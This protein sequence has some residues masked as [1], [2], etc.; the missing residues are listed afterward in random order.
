MPQDLKPDKLKMKRGDDPVFQRSGDLVA[1]A[2]Q[3]VKRVTCLSTVHTNNTCDK[4][5]RERGNP[6]GRQLEKPVMIEEY[7]AKMSGVD[8]MD[9]MLGSYAYCHKSTKWYQT[10]YHRVR[11]IALCNGYILLQFD[12]SMK[13]RDGAAFRKQVVDGLLSEY[14]PVVKSRG[15]PSSKPVPDRLAERHFTANYESKNYKPDCEV[16]SSRDPKKGKRHQ[17]NTYCKQCGI[18]MH[19]VDCF[20]RYHTLRD[21]R[22]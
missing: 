3:D 9:Q 13:C 20:E 21:Y 11:E 2:W 10:I 7:N 1:C 6:A 14:V 19:A 16:C 4:T 22:K 12:G 18:A 5:L 8:R 17:C 15:R